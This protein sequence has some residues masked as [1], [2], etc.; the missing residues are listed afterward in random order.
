MKLG[1]GRLLLVAGL[2][3]FLIAKLYMVL[4]TTAALAVP[5]LGDDSLVYL[6]KGRLAT[7][8]Y[9]A[10]LPAL[11]DIRTQRF[12]D[13][14]PSQTLAWMRS[15][16]AQRTLGTMTPAYDV[17][18]G[19]AL[20]VASDLRWA[21][22]LVEVAGVLLM[23]AGMGWFLMELCGPA[24]AGIAMAV[25]AFAVL[26]NQGI[27]SFIPSTLSLSCGL[28]LW[29]YLLRFGN[30]AR[31]WL[32]FA[33]ALAM[34]GLHPIAKVYVALSPMVLWL[35]LGRLAD[36]KAPAVLRTTAACAAAIAIGLLLP[37]MLPELRPP[38]SA[39]MGAVDL[40]EGLARNL[41]AVGPLLLD[42]VLRKNLL[43]A[44]L[45][46]GALV[47]ARR[48]IFTRSFSMPLLGVL[49]LLGISL[50]YFLPGYPAELFT[51][52][53]VLFVLFGAAAG[54]RF[55]VH[56]VDDGGLAR[57]LAI[58]VTSVGLLLS[59]AFWTG[60][61]V[62]SIMNWRNEVLL[63]Q[64]IRERLASLSDGTTLLYAETTFA[65]QASLALG[66]Y[67]LG[68][69]A[70]PMLAGTQSFD[71]L[72][73]ER[74]PPVL[75]APGYTALNSLAERRS[76]TFAPRRQGLYLPVVDRLVISRG[77]GLDLSEMQILVEPA[78]SSGAG[79]HLSWQAISANGQPDGAARSLALPMHKAWLSLPVPPDSMGVKLLFPDADAWILGIRS[80]ES[81][82]SVLWP[83]Q[84][85]WSL[86]YGFRG[87]NDEKPVRIEF[88]TR[89]LLDH[90][91]AA[92]LLPYVNSNDP[93][94]ADDGGLVFLRTIYAAEGS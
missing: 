51:R 47:V 45:F 36:C 42:P 68:A 39:I 38:P 54:G 93:V 70:Y 48:R 9:S 31:A 27:Y 33:V 34:V 29:A 72:L 76:K 91:Q 18:E 49:G 73:A 11:Q 60:R 53:L 71:R 40:R 88:T 86:V 94:L 3:V 67:R 87:K 4:L 79:V 43:W 50:V 57:T 52:L 32:V 59:A 28:L 44:A 82:H 46:L 78:S 19:L 14:K 12:L 22:A 90:A 16:V 13:D 25:M 20:G 92:D 26:P 84:A 21:S 30:G 83:W 35:R 85:G 77:E 75:V 1:S 74:R 24:A 10:N 80:G 5:R 2:L 81:A 15:N 55:I 66:G 37:L 17:V 62:P 58:G 61:Y 7:L 23:A 56:L 69:L 41:S 65:L 64:P 89:A 63:E 8:G 6:W